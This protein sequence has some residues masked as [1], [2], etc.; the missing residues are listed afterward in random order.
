MP[1]GQFMQLAAIH[2]AQ[3]QFMQ[4]RCNSLRESLLKT[5]RVLF[6]NLAADLR[7]LAAELIDHAVI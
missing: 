3:C 7:G 5:S 6:H 4:P 1:A 2:D